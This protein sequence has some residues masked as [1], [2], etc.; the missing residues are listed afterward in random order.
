MAISHMPDSGLR[1]DKIMF[2]K[3]HDSNVILQQT[4]YQLFKAQCIK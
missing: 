2:L 3:V 1:E 4:K